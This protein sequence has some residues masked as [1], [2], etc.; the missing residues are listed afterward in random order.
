M[1]FRWLNKCNAIYVISIFY[2]RVN[3]FLIYL[4]S[5]LVLPGLTGGDIGGGEYI[6]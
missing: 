5:N 3:I 4:I 6:E 2:W 1:N